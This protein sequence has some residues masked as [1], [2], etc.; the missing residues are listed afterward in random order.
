ML[1]GI[2]RYFTYQLKLTKI[3]QIVL[4]N[5]P[6]ILDLLVI[7]CLT[8]NK[9]SFYVLFFYHSA[10]PKHVASIQFQC[11]FC[12]SYFWQQYNDISS[13]PSWKIEKD[14]LCQITEKS[15]GNC[16]QKASTMPWPSISFTLKTLKLLLGCHCIDKALSSA[17]LEVGEQCLFQYTQRS[18][19]P[20]AFFA[21]G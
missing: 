17:Y 21:M 3:S 13:S 12:C 7:Y 2:L 18:S 19:I 15:I 6:E 20:Y 11:T 16:P 5:M 10:R 9:W 14:A 1:S 8:G 4:N